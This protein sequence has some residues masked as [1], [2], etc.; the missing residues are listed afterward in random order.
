MYRPQLEK[1]TLRITTP[2]L[3]EPRVD[4]VPGSQ[5]LTVSLIEQDATS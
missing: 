4:L 5:S 1:D 2:A 3:S